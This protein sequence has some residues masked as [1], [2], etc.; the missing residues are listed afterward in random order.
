MIKLGK[1]VRDKVTGFK[2][3][4]IAEVEYLFGC[5]QFG[6]SPKMN[7]AGEVKDAEFFDVGR[8]EV[9]GEGVYTE[10][11]TPEWGDVIKLGNEAEDI[12][13]GFKGTVIGRARYFFGE[14]RIGIAPKVS[15]NGE[16]KGHEYF[17]AKRVKVTGQGI[18][19]EEVQAEKK[20]GISRDM[21]RGIR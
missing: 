5:N 2:G 16:I 6:V 9:I 1:E 10:D 15:E 8:L 4:A 13:T 12:V 11:G 19:P 21:P 3:T 18:I 7:E 20:G 17:N 14:I